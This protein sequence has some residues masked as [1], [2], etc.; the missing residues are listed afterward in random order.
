MTHIF[1]IKLLFQCRKQ[2]V[3]CFNYHFK[4]IDGMELKVTSTGRE[5]SIHKRQYSNY[6]SN[7]LQL[8]RA[9]M[10]KRRQE[11]IGIKNTRIS[12]LKIKL[13]FVFMVQ[14]P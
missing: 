6:D 7:L 12:F 14:V 10:E 3:K 9:Y 5:I 13:T 1:Y 2:T 4:I 11:N 8:Y